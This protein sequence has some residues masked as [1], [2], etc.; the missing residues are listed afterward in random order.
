MSAQ[1]NLNHH[2]FYHGTSA[3][4]NPG[5]V[6]EPGHAETTFNYD[7]PPKHVYFTKHLAKAWN[8][9]DFRASSKGGNASVYEVEPIG[10]GT[11]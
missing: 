10:A 7:R 4:L 3:E 5:D 2:Q 1:D 9:A 11:P 6:V 8:Y